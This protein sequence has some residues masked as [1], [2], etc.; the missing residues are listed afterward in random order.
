MQNA[1]N[2]FAAVAKLT[3]R[4]RANRPVKSNGPTAD[5]DVESLRRRNSP[6]REENHNATFEVTRCRV[7]GFG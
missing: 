3:L 1:G 5:F 7:S 4:E 6:L 2:V